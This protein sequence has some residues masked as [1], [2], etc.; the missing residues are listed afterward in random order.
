MSGTSFTGNGVNLFAASALRSGL[1]MYARCGMR[2][3]RAWTPSA[4]LLKAG[5]LTGRT[6]K[7]G[8]YDEAVQALTELLEAQVPVAVDA[9][10][11]RNF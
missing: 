4:M 8:Q 11:I 3:N 7:R 2:P 1:R 6:F 10:E 5:Q 9:G